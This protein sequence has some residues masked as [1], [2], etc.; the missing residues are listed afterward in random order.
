[1]IKC[2]KLTVTQ[3]LKMLPK[4]LLKNKHI[5]NLCGVKINISK[6]RYVNFV[7]KGTKCF[8][9]GI[10]GEYFLIEKEKENSEYGV[11]NLY[12]YNEILKEDII[13]SSTTNKRFGKYPINTILCTNCQHEIVSHSKSKYTK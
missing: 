6:Q 12:G 1:M 7:N 9:C 10:K 3:A 5:I 8:N 4:T 2:G 11:I 13:I